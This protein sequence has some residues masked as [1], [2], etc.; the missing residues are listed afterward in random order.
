MTETCRQFDALIACL[1]QLT[2]D[3]AATLEAHLAGCDSCRDLARAVKPLALVATAS[4]DDIPS[5]DTLASDG[6]HLVAPVGRVDRQLPE[7]ATDRYVIASE[8]GRGGLGRVLQ[9][10]DQVLDRPVA[11]KELLRANDAMR[12]RFIREAL[13]T[14]RLQHP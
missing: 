4:P 14:A 12:R 9:A 2:P 11:V 8:V 1:A 3:E 6:P 13:I 7:L 5:A 10:R